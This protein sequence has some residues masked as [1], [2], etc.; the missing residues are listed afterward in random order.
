LELLEVRDSRLEV[1]VREKE[2]DLQ[3]TTDG[4]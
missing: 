3:K 4:G 1:R 2:R